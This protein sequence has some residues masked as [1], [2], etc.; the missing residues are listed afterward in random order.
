LF[1]GGDGQEG[2]FCEFFLFELSE[3]NA[4]NNLDSIF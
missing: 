1:G 4:A 3:A 2:D